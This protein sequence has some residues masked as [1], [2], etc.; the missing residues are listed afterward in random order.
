MKNYIDT[1]FSMFSKEKDK[2][3]KTQN[4]IFL[5]ILLVFVL[6]CINTISSDKSSVT[7][8]SNNKEIEENS[9][10][11]PTS[12]YN[13]I[14]DNL[15]NILG[16]ISGVSDVSVM[17][18]YSSEEKMIPV[19]DIKEEV[20]VEENSDGNET[21]TS[22]KTTTE[23][24]VAYEEANDRKVAIVESKT[25]PEIIG[26]IIAAKGIDSSNITKIKAAVSNSL[27]IPVHKVEIFSK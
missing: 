26:A 15:K 3:T 25:S 22:K 14:E 2:K 7:T 23:K 9:N 17:I 5:A 27:D 11:L 19:Y 4:L 6:I 8:L 16:Q 20:A 12:H 13:Y 21:N 18:T 10:N 1:I 24:T